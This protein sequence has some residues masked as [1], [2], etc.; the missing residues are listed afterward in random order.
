MLCSAVLGWVW[1]RSLGFGNR[2]PFERAWH[3]KREHAKRLEAMDV[4][5][6]VA[7][8]VDPILEKIA[9]TGMRSLSGGE[10]KMLQ[11]A[12]NKFKAIPDSANE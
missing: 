5:E 8:E 7:T 2:L 1:C 9:R 10:K 12:S 4:H 3:E 11:M 6:F